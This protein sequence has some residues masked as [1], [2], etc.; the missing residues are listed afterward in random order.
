MRQPTVSGIYRV[1]AVV[2]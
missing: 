2:V 1:H